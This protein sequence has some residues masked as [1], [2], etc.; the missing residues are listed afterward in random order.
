MR[1]RLYKVFMAELKKVMMQS[2]KQPGGREL[3]KHEDVIKF[4]RAQTKTWVGY[5]EWM[6]SICQ[7]KV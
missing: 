3:L 7:R 4:L 6:I 1:A 2:K 5:F